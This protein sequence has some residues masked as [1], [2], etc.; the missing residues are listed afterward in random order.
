MEPATRYTIAAHDSVE[1]IGRDRWEA[2]RDD[3]QPFS[4]YDFYR[5]L[6]RHECVGP[7]TGWWPRH[8]T[9]NTGGQ[10]AAL[11]P[12]YLKDHSWGEFV[13]DFAWA[14]A[15]A[16]AGLDYYPKLVAMC[17]FTPVTG[18]RV[19]S[20]GAGARTVRA[21]L[22]GATAFARQ[23]QASSVHV[24]YPDEGELAPLHDAG[25]LARRDVR[26]LWRDEGFE[27]FDDFLN[28]FSAKN[29]KKIRRERRRVAEQGITVE[30]VRADTLTR[31]EWRTVYGL[32]AITF[33]R[34]GHSPYLSLE[35]FLDLADCLGS[36]LLVNV[37]RANSQIVGAAI[38][39]R[40]SRNLYGRYWGGLP[41]LDCLHFETCYYRGIEYCI[42]QG[43]QTFDP[44][45]QGQHK[46]RRGFAPSLTHSGHWI[47]DPGFRDAID[48]YLEMER[49]GVDDYRDELQ[50]HLPF[51]QA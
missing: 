38:L 32:C 33:M 5:A 26:F 14:E 18:Q 28:A 9:A 39:F 40:D 21:L 50:D 24:L 49:T 45:T 6:E 44:G 48:R 10:P 1:T 27:G 35:F 19:L 29:R 3:D 46:L 43:L 13:F 8:L 20:A 25:M 15:Y 37:A 23:V 41:G 16:K 2:L 42:E 11:M 7:E 47:A 12:M 31:D 34:R 22:R 17:P 51:R 30:T 36:Q 4:S